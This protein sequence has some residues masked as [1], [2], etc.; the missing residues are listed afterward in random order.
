MPLGVAGR[1][2]ADK[3]RRI[4]LLEDLG[5]VG[6]I[7]QE[8][9]QIRLRSHAAISDDLQFLALQGEASA[10][11]D[12]DEKAR[13]PVGKGVA[14]QQQVARFQFVEQH[15]GPFR[16]RLHRGEKL[17]RVLLG[18][19]KV[20]RRRNPTQH[21]KHRR[22]CRFSRLG[23]QILIV[24]GC[25]GQGNGLG[26]PAMAF[27]IE[28]LLEQ[29]VEGGGD[30]KIEVPD[31]RQLAERLGHRRGQLL[32]QVADARVD[33]FPPAAT[34]EIAAYH[35]MESIVTLAVG[36]RQAQ[37]FGKFDG[38]QPLQRLLP[39]GPIGH[40]EQ[41]SA[42]DG[43]H[44]S[45]FNKLK[46]VVPKKILKGLGRLKHQEKL[47]RTR[48]ASPADIVWQRGSFWTLA[49]DEFK[50]L[51]GKQAAGDAAFSLCD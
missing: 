32:H 10:L 23:R 46:N 11:G 5:A 2:F 9:D 31:A 29:G 48:R 13:Q 17:Q 26:G 39:A 1:E 49:Q 12:A 28:G 7:F 37:S 36:R 44:L 24:I 27:L 16:L 30:K 50:L 22:H 18:D 19:D 42:D 3:F 15:I 33:L 47:K 51:L 21:V 8:E 14:D 40:V 45:I 25:V 43:N 20:G 41:L 38:Q 34:L 35:L 4:A 6:E